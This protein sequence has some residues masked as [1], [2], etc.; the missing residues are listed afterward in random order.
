MLAWLSRLTAI[1]GRAQAPESIIWR[2]LTLDARRPEVPVAELSR[3]LQ[4]CD[5]PLVA[6]ESKGLSLIYIFIKLFD[7]IMKIGSWITLDDLQKFKRFLFWEHFLLHTFSIPSPVQSTQRNRWKRHNLVP[8]VIVSTSG[9]L[10]FIIYFLMVALMVYGSSQYQ[11]HSC[12]N[13]GFSN[14]LHWT[15]DQTHASTATP[16][17]QLNS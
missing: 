6:F 17:L 10:F 16:V 1:S 5:C 3:V 4:P 14:P 13:A 8:G 2:D 15:G 12:S 7:T 9:I 11:C